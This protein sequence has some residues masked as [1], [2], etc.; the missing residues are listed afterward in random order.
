[1][2]VATRADGRIRK[3]IGAAEAATADSDHASEA[4]EVGP[5]GLARPALWVPVAGLALPDHTAGPIE[6][7]GSAA[8][9]AEVE[10]EATA[11]S[12]VDV[13]RAVNPAGQ[14][15]PGVH[16]GGRVQ[17]GAG[18]GT[19]RPGAGDGTVHPGA[20]DGTVHRSPAVAG[21]DGGEV[22][23]ADG[24]E[25]ASGT[26]AEIRSLR[27]TGRPL[28]APMRRSMESAFGT[29]LSDVRVHTGNTAARLNAG[30]QSA[31]FT[32]GRDIAFADGMPDTRTEGGQH[33]LAH[34]LAHVLQN[35]EPGPIRRTMRKKGAKTDT[36]LIDLMSTGTFKKAPDAI[37]YVL[38][39]WE[40]SGSQ[41]TYT[42]LNN[43]KEQAK[44][45]APNLDAAFAASLQ[46]SDELD[47]FETS[48]KRWKT[49]PDATLTKALD[50]RRQALNNVWGSQLGTGY[51]LPQFVSP[52][53]YSTPT[54]LFSSQA[55]TS[56]RDDGAW[57]TTTNPIVGTGGVTTGAP[58]ADLLLEAQSQGSLFKIGS[59]YQQLCT[60][61]GRMTQ[62]SQFEVDHQ[63]A[64]SDIRDNLIKLASAMAADA[65]LYQSVKGG[66]ADFDDLFSVIGTPGTKG[67]QVSAFGAVVHLYSNDMTNLMRICRSCN[68]PWGKSDM[69]MVSWFLKSPY[70][71]Q[72]FLD[73]YQL[74]GPHLQVIA[75]TKQGMGWG[76]AAREWFA[77]HHL[78]ILKNQEL[79]ANLQ[80]MVRQRLTEQST[81]GVNAGRETNPAKKQK[82]QHDTAQLGRN[83]EALLGPLEVERDYHSGTLLG[84][85]PY[86][87]APS[88]PS[89][90]KNEHIEVKKKREKRKR[91]ESLARRPIFTTGRQDGCAGND[92]NRP[93][94]SA[95]QEDIEAYQL[96]YDE[97]YAEYVKS[98]QDGTADALT[99]ELGLDVDNFTAPNPIYEAAF[100]EMLRKR[101]RAWWA[102]NDA[103]TQ[104]TGLDIGYAT[105]DPHAQTLLR[106][107]MFGYEHARQE[108]KK[109]VTITTTP[110]DVQMANQ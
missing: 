12:I 101:V 103:F 39:Y 95:D 43:L 30:L 7:I 1:M 87:F 49:P 97:G 40:T 100:K 10:A 65:L 8:D 66:T 37:K 38:R 29:D 76:E 83:N 52:S 67:C 17:Q 41:I 78:P 46:S 104:D 84:E 22:V 51:V 80:E 71:G 94:S 72:P 32:A 59:D 23:G 54:A 74:I 70:F 50:A 105:G 24:G 35:R 102:G 86:E 107:Y 88:S 27:G 92:T 19:V 63:Q 36:P 15:A 56:G 9:P 6:R 61:C 5:D 108:S 75:R 47:A 33:L 99:A 79:L 14:P 2:S 21:T 34:E 58:N 64:F 68:G 44:D 48:L 93:D 26:S 11:R 85:R 28:P 106:D 20:G 110:T 53:H 96:G 60:T 62:A 82:L 3:P 57:T 81:T 109:P 91:S 55:Q 73:E 25:L 90:M 31:A 18:G 45:A 4:R 16:Q 69:D 13:L 42:T 98:Q 77:T 89:R